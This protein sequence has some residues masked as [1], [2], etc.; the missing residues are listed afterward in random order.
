MSKKLFVG[1]LTSPSTSPDKVKV[2]KDSKKQVRYIGFDCL[3]NGE[4]RLSFTIDETSRDKR[5]ITFDFAGVLF[6]GKDRIL[7]QEAAGI[8]Y[9][10]LND[11][12]TNGSDISPEFIVTPEDIL[13][14]KQVSHR[15]SGRHAA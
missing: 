9:S 11:L 6:V 7:L 13:R 14:Y 8:C 3:L 15:R 4:R 5:L 12:L 2:M 1:N 10:K